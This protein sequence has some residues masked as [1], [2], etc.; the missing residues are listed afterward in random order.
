[1]YE[2]TFLYIYLSVKRTIQVSKSNNYSFFIKQDF[3]IRD[4]LKKRISNSFVSHIFISR[5][6]ERLNVF[7]YLLNFSSIL[8]DGSSSNLKELL[9]SLLNS[10]FGVILSRLDFIQVLDPYSLS[11]CVCFFFK[12]QLEKRVPFRKAI[13]D[14]V[15]QIKQ[16]NSILKGLKIQISGRLNGA[17][18]ARTEWVK[19]GQVPLHTLSANIDYSF[20][21]AIVILFLLI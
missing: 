7:V 4:F 8:K 10:K 13:V 1:M 6:S 11:S 14:I 21:D 18:I 19:E 16:K 2:L 3:F 15:S 20:L 17:E 5:K 9:S 12:K